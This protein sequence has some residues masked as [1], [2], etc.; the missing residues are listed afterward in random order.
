MWCLSGNHSRSTKINMTYMT[1]QNQKHCAEERSVCFEVC[2]YLLLKC[3]VKRNC[4]CWVCCYQCHMQL[5]RQC[6][7]W[8]IREYA[9]ALWDRITTTCGYC[10]RV[11]WMTA[12]RRLL[13][14]VCSRCGM[15]EHRNCQRLTQLDL[16]LVA[17]SQRITTLPV[18]SDGPVT[19]AVK[20]VLLFKLWTGV[21][22]S[23]M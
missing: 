19:H 6:H 9:A 17:R 21:C 18:F 3:D 8:C 20:A 5:S 11:C 10:P 7:C 13:P 2:E 12:W 16:Q 23:N 22:K 15:F 1:R 4:S 14:Q